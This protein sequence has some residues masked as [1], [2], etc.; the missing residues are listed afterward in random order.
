MLRS[1]WP[2][3]MIVS[4]IP[5]L[6]SPAN[7]KVEHCLLNYI[8]NREAAAHFIQARLID[9]SEQFHALRNKLKLETSANM[10]VEKL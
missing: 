9:K 8:A 1:E 10:A 7:S 6:D 3:E 4:L 2:R 5:P